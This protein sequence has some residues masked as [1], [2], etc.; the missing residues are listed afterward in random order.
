MQTWSMLDAYSGL[1]CMI[2]AFVF[3]RII[4]CTFVR[5]CNAYKYKPILICVIRHC[6]FASWRGWCFC[7]TILRCHWFGSHM[8]T[9]AVSLIFFSSQTFLLTGQICRRSTALLLHISFASFVVLFDLASFSI[10]KPE[11]GNKNEYKSHFKF[12][13]RHDSRNGCSHLTTIRYLSWILNFNAVIRTW[14]RTRCSLFEFMK[15][16]IKMKL[17]FFSGCQFYL[18]AIDK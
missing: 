11:K 12:S 10:P 6:W 2:V 17:D 1:P 16:R 7:F 8:R 5:A 15:R 4:L 9:F 18:L 3:Y 14:H 13:A